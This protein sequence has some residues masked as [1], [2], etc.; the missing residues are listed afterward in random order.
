VDE[1]DNKAFPET[2]SGIAAQGKLVYQDLGCIAC[3]TQQVRRPG[4]GSDDKRHWGDRQSVARDYVRESRVLLGSSRLGPDLRNLGARQSGDEGRTWNYKHLYDAQLTS[5]G[6][7]MP[8]YPFLFETRKAIGQYSAKSIQKYLP[9]SDQPPAGYEIV[10]T[11]RGEALVEYLVSLKDTYNY[12]EEA[13]RVYTPPKPE[14]AAKKPEGKAEAKPGAKPEAKPD[15]KADAKPEGKAEAK[16][17]A[18]K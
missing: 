11:H 4:F 5:P 9:P 3:H 8:S 1:G 14:G 12:P 2:L 7:T 13:T 15:G 16:P 10:P 17:E 6:S 18:H